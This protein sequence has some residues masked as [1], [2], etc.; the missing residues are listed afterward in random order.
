MGFFAKF[1]TNTK[2]ELESYKQREQEY[3]AALFAMQN[4]Q[5]FVG[6]NT[7]NMPQWGTED[8]GNA[9]SDNDQI[10]S[11]INKIAETT[12]LLPAFVYEVKRDS[13]LKQ[14]KNITARQVY[15]TKSLLDVVNIQKKSLED[16]PE[17]DW[18]VKL[19]AQ[20]NPYQNGTEFST[21]GYIYYLLFG[22]VI[23][24]KVRLDAGDN[25]GKTMEIYWLPPS[26]VELELSTTFPRQILSYTF[27]INGQAV[28]DKEPASEF[29]HIRKTNPKITNNGEE[30]RGLSPLK[31]FGFQRKLMDSLDSRIVTQVDNGA[32]SGILY[33]KA[34]EYEEGMQVQLDEK[35]SAIVSF[36]R[37]KNNTG[38]PY[39]TA[40]D[41]GYIATGL[42]LADMDV[43]SVVKIPFKRLCNVYK[44]SDILFN[45]DAAATESNV[46]AMIKQMI[47]NACLPLATTFGNAYNSQ[48]L[49][50]S[51]DKPRFY[52][53]DVSSIP[54]LQDNMKDMA[55]AI[56]ALP[57]IPSGNAVLA[58]FKFEESS[59]P[60]MQVPLIKQGY[61][62]IT[63]LSTPEPQLIP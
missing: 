52:N 32:V 44:I 35:R 45:S 7:V 50:E 61:S 25:T 56:S 6:N 58:L 19:L 33:D 38:I 34:I 40:G 27:R 28:L 48:L 63:D 39:Y 13:N 55:D 5:V 37:N 26:M 31:P 24:Y 57:V 60:N 29:I 21:A 15:N 36:S 3:K 1:F 11:V 9:Y 10:Y 20:P 62:L 2:Q 30:F 23:G 47:M 42:K 41:I 49:N 18:Y 54:E 16:L 51:N 4:R 43:Q 17:N 53:M 46:E 22:E 59:E 12:A 14:L 8:T